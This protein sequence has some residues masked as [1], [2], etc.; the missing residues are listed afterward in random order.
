MNV[1]TIMTFLL[2]VPDIGRIQETREAVYL[3]ASYVLV[4]NT[5]LPLS[6]LR[7]TWT[8]PSYRLPPR[9]IL[10]DICLF[11]LLQA[12]ISTLPLDTR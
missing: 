7:S 2:A 3:R 9:P 12:K 4:A 10:S 6:I 5:V 1:L 11:R 8:P